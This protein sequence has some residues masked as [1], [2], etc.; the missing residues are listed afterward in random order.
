M[1]LRRAA[2]I[3]GPL[4]LAVC[5][6]GRPALAQSSAGVAE[7][8]QAYAAVDY[9]KTR[10]LSRAALLQGG[11]DRAATGELYLLWA[12]AAAALDLTEE[13][14]DAFLHALAVNPELKLDRSLSPKIRAPYQ[15]A[16]GALTGADGKAPL[17]VALQRRDRQLEI[18]V[19][20][21]QSL[22]TQ[23]ELAMRRSESQPFTQQR[24]H[25]TPTR[26][27]TL[28]GPGEL[29]LFV[30]LLDSN[31]NVLLELGNEAEPRR[32]AGET[33]VR[34]DAPRASVVDDGRKP[35]FITAA[36]LAAVGLA[37]GGVATGFYLRRENQARDWNGPSCEKPGATREQQ[38]ADVDQRRRNAERLSM[39]FAAA[40][41]TLLI[42]S[43]V[44]LFLVPSPKQPSIALD[45]TPSSVVLR[46]GTTL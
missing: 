41:G 35:Y 16:R 19:H 46:L 23:V 11:N 39:G 44:T 37:A 10:E 21:A 24:F 18:R 12:T 40:G 42:G 5:T 34:L 36:T 15:E 3:A 30:R 33:A 14:R 22:A 43:L 7:A 38:C 27:V 31:G 1:M 8:R 28:A 25:V 4:L 9:E 6:S 26:L 29:R 2:R 20:D 45:T 13:A 32:L 17:E